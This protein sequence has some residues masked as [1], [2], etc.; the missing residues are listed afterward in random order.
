MLHTTSLAHHH[1]IY[2][3]AMTLC[4]VHNRHSLHCKGCV[5]YQLNC[6]RFQL[7]NKSILLEPALPLYQIIYED[8]LMCYKTILNVA[9]HHLVNST[10]LSCTVVLLVD[11]QVSL[12]FLVSLISNMIPT[13]FLAH[14]A[15][16]KARVDPMLKIKCT[17]H[18]R[19]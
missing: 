15:L 3:V 1:R 7:L 17:S 10:Q 18:T 13:D 11:V 12:P 6:C 8:T 4:E 5:L 9:N 16:G 14:F 19:H 2:P